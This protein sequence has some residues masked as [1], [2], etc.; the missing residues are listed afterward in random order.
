[1]LYIVRGCISVIL[2]I[3]AVQML[4][5]GGT[6]TQEVLD[7]FQAQ[8]QTQNR[9]NEL[10]NKSETDKRTIE[11]R[12]ESLRAKL[13]EYKYSESRDADKYCLVKPQHL[14]ATKKLCLIAGNLAVWSVS[15]TKSPINAHDVIPTKRKSLPRNKR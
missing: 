7:K 8:K 14:Q 13:D 6:S 5:S 1:M 9:L 12:I 3:Q 2:T 10:R 4:V 15:S 11:K